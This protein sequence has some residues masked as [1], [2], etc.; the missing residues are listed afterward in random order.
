MTRSP[1]FRRA[2][3]ASTMTLALTALLAC[4]T[5]ALYAHEWPS[6]APGADRTPRWPSQ[7]PAQ[8]G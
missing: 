2:A 8:G 1:S 5:D 6:P 7:R 4:S 3:L